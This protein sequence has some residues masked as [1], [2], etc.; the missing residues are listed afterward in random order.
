VLPKGRHFGRQTKFGEVVKDL[1]QIFKKV[2]PK[3]GQILYVA[4]LII[5]KTA[6]FPVNDYN[7]PL[8]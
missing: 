2:G 7:Y 1:C 5:I 8:I 3:R 6:M 4:V